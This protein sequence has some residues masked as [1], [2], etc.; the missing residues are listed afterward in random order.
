MR[1]D[2][3]ADAIKAAVTEM[4]LGWINSLLTRWILSR[5]RNRAYSQ[6]EFRQMVSETSFKT[7]EMKREL[8]GVK[9]CLVK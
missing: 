1:S 3:T 6:D 7:C 4:G 9:V 8:I 2:V 5:L